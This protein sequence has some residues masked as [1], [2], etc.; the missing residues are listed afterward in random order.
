MVCTSLGSLLHPLF[1]FLCYIHFSLSVD[2]SLKITSSPD[3]VPKNNKVTPEFPV[4]SAYRTRQARLCNTFA[5]SSSIDSGWWCLQSS[6]LLANFRT[7]EHHPSCSLPPPFI[8]RTHPAFRKSGCYARSGRVHQFHCSSFQSAPNNQTWKNM[9][10]NRITSK[11][12]VYLRLWEFQ[13]WPWRITVFPQNLTKL[14]ISVSVGHLPPP[15][16]SLLPESNFVLC[17]IS[18]GRFCARKVCVFKRGMREGRKNG[19]AVSG[20]AAVSLLLCLCSP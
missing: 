17:E 15:S 2:Q 18:R 6:P 4:D 11:Q 14:V 3:R 12:I 5:L 16:L 9:Y 8:R 7:R 19:G 20:T 1:Y 10:S 13:V